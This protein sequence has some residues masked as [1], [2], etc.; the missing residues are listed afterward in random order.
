[1]VIYKKPLI[2]NNKMS[3]AQ[4]VIDIMFGDSGKG[5]T[6]NYLCSQSPDLTKIVVRF[7]GGQQAGHTVIKNGVKHIHSNFTCGV[8]DGLTSYFTE[9]C[10]VYPNYIFKER[11]KLIGKGIVE[12]RL[13]VHP[14]TM[15]TTPSDVAY[16]RVRERRVKHGSCGMGIGSTMTRNNTTGYKLY[17]IDII[18]HDLFLTK[19]GKIS[20]YYQSILNKDDIKEFLEIEKR[21]MEL[22]TDIYNSCFLISGYDY[23][24][25]FDLVIFEGS[26]G[27]LLDMDHGIFP[28][29][30]YANT[31]SKNAI[32]V[33]KILGISDIEIFYVTRCYQTR[34]GAGWM[35]N[36][37]EVI[38]INNEEEINVSNSWQGNFRTG[39]MDYDLLNYAFNID[40]QYSREVYKRN[41]VVTCLDQR[42]SFQL[43]YDR[44]D[45]NINEFYSSSSPE[46]VKLKK[47]LLTI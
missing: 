7:S 36:E 31:T 28:N 16:N 33:C 12:P 37:D 29:V 27:I 43:Q 42:P 23:V 4:I 18:N 21:E 11:E 8:M 17:A 22:Y 6:T 41:L 35:S 24:K 10:T 20:E 15:L 5:L 40:F 1:M 19:L 38:L 13:I 46:S 9:H 26:Q 45:R 2:I 32:A 14:F 39:E 25:S 47:E 44:I 3:K 34:H 30:T